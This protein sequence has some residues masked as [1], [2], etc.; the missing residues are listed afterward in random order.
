MFTGSRF[1]DF[2]LS[3]WH[4]KVTPIGWGGANKMG[5]F[6][7]NCCVRGL[8]QAKVLEFLR[9]NSRPG[10]VGA[11]AGEWVAFVTSDLETQDEAIIQNYGSIMTKGSDRLFVSIV[12]HDEDFLK[13]DLFRE[14][15]LV[16]EF[17]SCP[18]YF[19]DNPSDDPSAFKPVLKGAEV[20]SE[21]FHLGESELA[22]LVP[23][24]EF[25]DV[26]DLHEK[27]SAALGLPAYAV[28]MGYRYV[29]RG[30]GGSSWV[31]A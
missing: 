26:F 17:N 20:L 25:T 2:I 14:G 12:C 7:V 9:K 31:A 10:Y 23:D 21:V 13:I 1:A 19:S 27:W 29:N 6:Y 8:G 24:A 22:T 16:S 18:G 5:A 15:A 4:V 30:E 28:G 11:D 3:Y